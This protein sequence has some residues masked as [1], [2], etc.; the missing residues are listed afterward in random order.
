M[1]EKKSNPLFD[2]INSLFTNKEYV[3]NITMGFAKQNLFMVLR[4]IA[5][6]YPLQ[7]NTFNDN[8]VNALD[9]IKFLSDFLYCGYAPKWIYTS[10]S[11]K[12]KKKELGTED[13]KLYKEKNDITDKDF[14]DA[15]RFFPKE[16]INEV[17]ELSE[18]YAKLNSSK[19]DG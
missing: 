14:Q 8:K 16:L 15:M 7:A 10:A 11:S 9:T 4:R 5:I 18:L 3:N 17:K 19:I 13:V 2:L 6:Q 1:A 12:T